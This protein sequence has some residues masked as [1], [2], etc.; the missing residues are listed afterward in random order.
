MFLYDLVNETDSFTASDNFIPQF[1][2]IQNF[3]VP[4]VTKSYSLSLKAL[5]WTQ[6]WDN[7]LGE[8]S[9]L[10]REIYDILLISLEKE[11][12]Y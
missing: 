8:V 9:S 4:S 1:G 6:E 11:W 5:F 10:S 3:I 12:I 2:Q 7:L